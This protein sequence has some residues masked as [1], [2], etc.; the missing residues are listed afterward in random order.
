MGRVPALLA[1]GWVVASAAV[2]SGCATPEAHKSSL[3]PAPPA[4]APVVMVEE[5]VPVAVAPPPKPVA[6]PDP[7]GPNFYKLWYAT[8][9]TPHVV[10]GEIVDYS[11]KWDKQ[12]VHYG[13]VYVEMP[14]D[15]L[16]KVANRAF[17]AK[18]FPTTEAKLRVAMP[19]ETDASRFISQLRAEL[20]GDTDDPQ[21]ILLYLHG[22]NT[23]FREAAQ[24]AASIG[25]QLKMPTTAFFSWPSRGGSVAHYEADRDVADVSLDAIADFIIQAHA[26]SGAKKVHLIAHSMGNYA[27]LNALYR[28]KM[29]QAIKNG[30]RFGQVILA[31]PDVDSDRFM[32]DAGILAGLADRVSLYVSDGDKALMASRKLAPGHGRAGL[33]PPIV[34]VDGIDTVDVSHTNLTFLGHAFVSSEVAVLADMH[35]LIFYNEAPGQRVNMQRQTGYWKLQ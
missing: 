20:R 14:D 21:Q 12:H 29:Q 18:L 25:Y 1:L 23:T 13:S 5:P 27:L 26:D 3:A 8:N 6:A 15:F 33:R 19:V 17:Y 16:Q 34:M 9:R 31:A 24:R 7:V 4:P 35:N 30:L 10:K 28:P 32:K 11:A 2:V 22:F